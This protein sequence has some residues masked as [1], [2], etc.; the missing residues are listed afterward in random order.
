MALLIVFTAAVVVLAGIGVAVS[1]TPPE[2]VQPLAFNH[3]LHIDDVGLECTDCHLYVTSGERTVVPNIQG[4]ADCHFDEPITESEAEARLLEHIESEQ[5]IPWRQIYW[6]PDH[7]YFSHRRHTA[8]AEIPCETCHGPVAERTEPLTR[9]LAPIDMDT[10]M[11]C[12]YRT[13]ASNDCIACHR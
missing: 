3:A 10:C 12:H 1:T 2:V 4:C 9:R 6:V 5:P 13:E 8:T 11:D 7:V